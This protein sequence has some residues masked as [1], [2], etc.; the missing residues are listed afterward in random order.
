MVTPS[1]TATDEDL[2]RR[3][4]QHGHRRVSLAEIGAHLRGRSA[5][6]RF[7]QRFA[8]LVI[9][10]AGSMWCAYA[11]AA[12]A[13]IS[14]PAAI[15]SGDAVILVSWISQTF[16]QLVLLSVI[17]VGQQVISQA[18][19]ARAEADHESLQP[20]HEINTRQLAILEEERRS[21]HQ[22]DQK[23]AAILAHLGG[24]PPA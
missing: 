14:L 12:L 8:V 6:G 13:F 5:A 7:N 20:L 2:L 11:F 24:P 16:L 17:M 9:I 18:Q 21:R 22:Q 1:N 4:Q 15:R 19:D 10:A 23:V 3:A